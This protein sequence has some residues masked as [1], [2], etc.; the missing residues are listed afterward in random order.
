[1]TTHVKYDETKDYTN[2][3][4]SVRVLDIERGTEEVICGSSRTELTVRTVIGI[5]QISARV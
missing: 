4:P 5:G 1:M 2:I 3:P